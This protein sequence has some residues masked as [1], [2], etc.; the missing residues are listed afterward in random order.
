MAESKS[1][2]GNI[3]TTRYKRCRCNADADAHADAD[4]D[5]DVDAEPQQLPKLKVTTTT[6]LEYTLRG[7]DEGELRISG[8]GKKG[9]IRRSGRNQSSL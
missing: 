8:F 3:V 5:A 2:R 9:M 1:Y 6:T 4:A 7:Y